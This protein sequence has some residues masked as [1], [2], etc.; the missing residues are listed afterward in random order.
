MKEYGLRPVVPNPIAWRPEDIETL[1]TSA[2]FSDI[3]IVEERH[4]LPFREAS[5]VWG[6]TLSVGPIEVMLERLSKNE[7]QEFIQA[8][9]SRI[10]ELATPEGI[11]ANFRVLYV[12]A[13]GGT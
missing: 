3:E 8:F 5:E 10:Q 12:V 1:L 9:L 2:G 6:F 4:D 7:R 13:K 11:L